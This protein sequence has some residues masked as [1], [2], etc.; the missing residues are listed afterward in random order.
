MVAAHEIG[1]ALGLSHSKEPGALM[2]P[3]HHGYYTDFIL[4]YDDAVA[5]QQLYGKVLQLYG[6][7]TSL[8]LCHVS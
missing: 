5:I 7:L 8:M 3:W 6:K 2:S 1:H 4:P